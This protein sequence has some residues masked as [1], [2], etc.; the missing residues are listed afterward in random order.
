MESSEKTSLFYESCAMAIP[1]VVKMRLANGHADT[2]PSN[3]KTRRRILCE[4]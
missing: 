2:Q 3:Q 4:C 1:Y